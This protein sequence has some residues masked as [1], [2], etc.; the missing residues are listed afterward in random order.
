MVTDTSPDPHAYAHLMCHVDKY[1]PRCAM[2][3]GHRA[4][5]VMLPL[6]S[7]LE[8]GLTQAFRIG[9]PLPPPLVALESLVWAVRLCGLGLQTRA[10][11]D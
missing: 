4:R 1:S 10:I 3:R 6:V 2:V 5:P 8:F 9:M 11:I 7:Q